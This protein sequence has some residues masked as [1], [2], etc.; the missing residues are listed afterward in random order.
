MVI[1]IL[2]VLGLIWGS[3]INALVWRLHERA[4]GRKGKRYSLWRGRSMCPYCKH[5]LRAIDLVPIASWVALGGKCRYC[6]KPIS[7]QYPLVEALTALIFVGS[8]LL[9]PLPLGGGSATAIFGL[10]LAMVV[11]LVSLAIYDLKWQL[12]PDKL[13]LLLGV[14]AVVQAVVA[15]VAAGDPLKSLVYRI[16]AALIGGGLFLIIFALNDKWIGGGD[17]KLGFVIGLIVATPAKS[18]LLI[19]LAALIGTS[20]SLP[21]L[22]SKRLKVKSVVAFGP[23]LILATALVVIFGQPIIDWYFSLIRLG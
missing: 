9:W 19:F 11:L 1:A 23:F 21:L 13:V 12:L 16:T 15:I 10:W 14:I 17:V 2:A 20:V 3:F 4:E 6:K 5:E 7:I 8:Y 18:I 22:A